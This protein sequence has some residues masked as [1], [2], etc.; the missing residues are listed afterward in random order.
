MSVSI[1]G[2]RRRRR[3]K[4]WDPAARIAVF[5]L[6]FL[7]IFSE[8]CLLSSAEKLSHG[9][10]RWSPA[11]KARI[12][13]SRPYHA[14]ASSPSEILSYEEDKRLVHTGPNPLHN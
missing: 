13:G 2:E 9:G 12:Y 10:S 3:R 4:R 8:I 1:E 5:C 6:G 7:L 14:R 11:R